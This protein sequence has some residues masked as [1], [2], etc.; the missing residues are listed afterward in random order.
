[1]IDELLLVSFT[2]KSL[3]GIFLLVKYFVWGILCRLTFGPTIL[4]WQMSKV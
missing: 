3:T 1:M 4:S 2:V